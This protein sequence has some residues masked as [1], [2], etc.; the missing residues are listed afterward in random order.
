MFKI[1]KIND[2]IRVTTP[3]NA[4][5]V[6][7]V[8]NIH[9]KWNA[10]E[11]AWEVSEDAEIALLNLLKEIYAY[12]PDAD[13][14]ERVT[15]EYDAGEIVAL[16]GD[17]TNIMFSGVKIAWRTTRDSK[18]LLHPATIIIEGDFKSR[19]GSRSYPSLG[20]CDGVVLR[21]TIE[22]HSYDALSDEMKAKMTIIEK[23]EKDRRK[24]LEEL[25]EKLLKQ[26]A[27][28]EKELEELK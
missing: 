11:K 6:R 24:E 25:R 16:Q 8:K 4:Q 20:E 17:D 27:D 28:V 2:I 18:V 19:G 12:S 13:T 3:Y 15:V 1:E 21:T 9:G 10:D 14:G 26:L 7:R 23:R 22:K 5:F